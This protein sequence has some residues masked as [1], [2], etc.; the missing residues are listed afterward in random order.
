MNTGE[1]T[2]GAGGKELYEPA[3]TDNP[4]AWLHEDDNNVAYCAKFYSRHHSLTVI[5]L[6]AHALTLTQVNEFGQPIDR[7]RVTKS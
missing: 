3:Y 1:I 2:T 4:S 7:I 6:D 5:D